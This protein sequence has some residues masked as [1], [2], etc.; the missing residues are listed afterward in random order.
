MA[1]IASAIGYLHEEGFI[2]R[3]LKPEN[4]LLDGSG[5][6]TLLDFGL[7]RRLKKD[8]KVIERI[9]TLDYMSPEMVL[10]K[11]HW[12]PV[13]WW[14]LGVL[15]YEMLVGV[16]PFSHKSK[17]SMLKWIVE[18]TPRFPENIRI[19]NEAK[20]FCLRVFAPLVILMVK[21]RPF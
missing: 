2:Y 15:V 7:S 10:G 8:Q 12:F 21:M 3:D 17:K 13:D 4:V 9:G 1:Q 5:N 19:S 20:A 16:P 6:V 18:A 14:S 11:E